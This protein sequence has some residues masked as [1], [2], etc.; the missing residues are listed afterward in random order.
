MADQGERATDREA[1][2][3]KGSG[4]ATSTASTARCGPA[5]RWCG[6]GGAN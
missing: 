6:R 5:C 1:L 2:V 4:L 3:T